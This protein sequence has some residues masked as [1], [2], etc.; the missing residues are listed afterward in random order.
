MSR[1]RPIHR[2]DLYLVTRRTAGRRFFLRP[3]KKL[4]PQI[5]YC[6]A[7]AAARH[8]IK[9]HALVVMSNHW[10]LVASDPDATMPAFLRDA[11]AWIAKTTNNALGRW[12]NLWSTTQTS[13]VRSSGDD[14]VLGSIVYTMA[15]PVAAGLVAEGT[16]WPGLRSCWPDE[17][18]PVERPILFR[19]TGPMP[20]SATLEFHRP[21]GF[22]ELD[23][24]ALRTKIRRA[25]DEREAGHSEVLR[26]V[27]RK[28]LGRRAA[29]KQSRNDSPS[30]RAPRRE[31]S[32]RVAEK[33]TRRR[34][35]ALL[36]LQLFLDEYRH[37]LLLWRAGFREAVFPAGT[38]GLRVGAS[39]C[40]AP[41]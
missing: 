26:G 19:E 23:D 18:R 33:D 20:E 6:I 32:P 4:N 12:E 31:I 9:V 17:R 28:A 16:K 41:H 14:N 11:H 3:S 5:E 2:G 36:R 38:Y 34:I 40:C 10:H 24:G 39:V 22:D 37:A 13:L 8:K 27:G 21:P 15:N 29:R 7:V 30:S 35:Q 1:P 25:I